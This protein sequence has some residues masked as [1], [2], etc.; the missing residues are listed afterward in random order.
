MQSQINN[1]KSQPTMG[2]KEAS[3]TQ[4]NN[5]EYVHSTSYSKFNNTHREKL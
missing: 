2:E 5:K 1:K 3:V 4:G